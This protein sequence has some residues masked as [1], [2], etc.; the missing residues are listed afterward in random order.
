M[1]ADM[2]EIAISTPRTDE[3]SGVVAALVF[4]GDSISELA[5]EVA[6]VDFEVEMDSDV[7]DALRDLGAD[8][9]SAIGEAGES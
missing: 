2:R 1:K 6:A 5:E 3:L 9:A 8:I 7:S 4:I